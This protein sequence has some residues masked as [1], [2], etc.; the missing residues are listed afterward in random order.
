MNM[1]SYITAVLLGPPGSGKGTQA[2]L[3][4][5]E[6]SLC[7][8][9]TGEMF[10]ESVRQKT[11]LGSIVEDIMRKGALVPDDIL[12]KLVKEKVN[13]IIA[14]RK[15]IL[16]DGYPR[17]LVQAEQL[18]EILGEYG[19]ELGGVIFIDVPEDILV[20]R[21]SGRLYCPRCEA[22]YNV[23]FK[24]PM[25]DNRCDECGGELTRRSEDYPEA[26]R[27]RLTV[28]NEQTY[29][30]LNYYKKQGK[31]FDV[32]GEKSVERVFADI[33]CLINTIKT[34]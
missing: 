13:E 4:E 24:P 7:H 22:T 10:R 12:Y 6:F 17:T 15:D 8:F 31:L 30:V 19:I 18:D 3:L 16:F 32:N 9:S 29:P 11:E 2:E 26:I 25:Q 5:V 14:S 23:Y 34:R 33:A 1:D 27:A 20:K 28:Y 21:L